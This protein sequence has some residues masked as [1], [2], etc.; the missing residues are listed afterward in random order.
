MTSNAIRAALGDISPETDPA[1]RGWRSGRARNSWAGS[2]PRVARGVGKLPASILGEVETLARTPFDELQAPYAA[3]KLISPE[4]LLVEHVLISVYPQPFEPAA[5]CARKLIA[6]ALAGQVEM[7]WNEARRLAVQENGGAINRVS[8]REKWHSLTVLELAEM[9]R[10][11]HGPAL[12]RRSTLDGILRSPRQESADVGQRDLQKA[13][14][15]RLGRPSQVRGK[16]A[17]L[18][19]K[20]WMVRRRGLDG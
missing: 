1:P 17:V 4:D 13:R 11:E 3:V 18:R 14:A 5:A 9:P 10:L 16:D 20:Q 2:G 6:V 8:E 19:M 15:G 7:D 12:L